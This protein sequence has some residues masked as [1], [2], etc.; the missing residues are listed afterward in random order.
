M[1]KYQKDRHGYVDAKEPTIWDIMRRASNW[2]Q[3]VGWRA[4]ETDV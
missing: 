2:S 1:K 4:G 3:Q